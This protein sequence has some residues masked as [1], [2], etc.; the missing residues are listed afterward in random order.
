MVI[1]KL[2]VIDNTLYKPYPTN[3]AP[4]SP[5]D[6]NPIPL[7]TVPTTPSACVKLPRKLAPLSSV[8]PPPLK[9]LPNDVSK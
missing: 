1:K 5:A 7:A 4:A 8:A 6:I 9:D 3:V 2:P